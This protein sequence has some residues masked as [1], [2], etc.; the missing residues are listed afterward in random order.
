MC[1]LNESN[2]SSNH[3]LLCGFFYFR[4]QQEYGIFHFV[5]V[6]DKLKDKGIPY[7]NI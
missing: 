2:T 7:I 5:K 3:Q 4:S 1:A 6:K